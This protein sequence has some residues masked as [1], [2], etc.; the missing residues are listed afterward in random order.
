MSILKETLS[1]LENHLQSLVEGSAA[2]LYPS[3]I[4]N[5]DLA[6][7]L[8]QAMEATIITRPD[9]QVI[10][11]NLYTLIIN[12]AS[13]DEI[14]ESKSLF[15]DLARAIEEHGLASGFQ[16]LKSPE[17]HIEE[18]PQI[19]PHELLVLARFYQQ[20]LTPTTGVDQSDL[21]E[22]VPCPENAYLVVDGT[23]FF[24]LTQ[25]VVNIGRRP[26]N[27]LVINDRRVSRIHAQLR[28]L[29]GFY[30]IFDL[31]T[32]GGTFVNGQKINQCTLYPGDVISLAGLPL[33]FGQ[34]E[35]ELGE[36]QQYSPN[37]DR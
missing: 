2:R 22:S 1:K 25:P 29:N 5:Q 13:G 24:Q 14:R 21:P 10:A 23:L 34:D 3:N 7:R 28:A 16:F 37:L 12:P 26:D 8:T 9:G 30:I 36:T 6:H 32:T 17:I 4:G 27:Q 11:P 35:Y 20:D 33:I 15:D 19:P 31:D 18:D